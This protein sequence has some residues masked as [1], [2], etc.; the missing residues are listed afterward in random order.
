MVDPD[1]IMSARLLGWAALVVLGGCAVNFGP[2][3]TTPVP[4]HAIEAPR[5]Q[6]SRCTRLSTGAEGPYRVPLAGAEEDPELA[7]LLEP[8]PSDLRR[9]MLAAGLEPVVA[10]LLRDQRQGEGAAPDFESLARR[11]AVSMHLGSL[12]V[13]VDALGFE[14][15]CTGDLVEAVR[16]SIERDDSRREIRQTVA[17]LVVGAAATIAAGIWDLSQED[18]R[19]A[20]ALDIAGATV[21]AGL[22]VAAF[23]P[24]PRAIHLEHRRNLLAPIVRGEDPDHVYPTFVFRLFTLPTPNGKTRRDALVERFDQILRDAVDEADLPRAEALL[25][26]DGGTYDVALLEAREKMFDELEIAVGASSRNLE[27]LQRFLGR[28]FDAEW[29]EAPER[30]AAE[31]V[32]AHEAEATPLSPAPD[33]PPPPGT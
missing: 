18:S 6:A 1:R 26:G 20:V 33:A 13:Q 12:K 27:V 11:Q 30:G 2:S 5:G 25:Y 9:T 19:G 4:R 16:A 22:G 32:E 29:L 21:A 24:K 28:T 17:S 31:E 23:I 8:L 15:D 14:V 3:G 10:R 7:A